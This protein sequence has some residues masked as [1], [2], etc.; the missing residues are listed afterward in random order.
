MPE[1][2][3]AFLGIDVGNV[4]LKYLKVRTQ[5]ASLLVGSNCIAEG[6]FNFDASNDFNLVSIFEANI[7]AH[8][9]RK[10]RYCFKFLYA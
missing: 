9:T 3:H 5:P 2:T 8:R 4:A 7:K 1:S 6:R 10:N